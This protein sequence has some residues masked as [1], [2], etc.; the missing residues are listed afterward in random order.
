MDKEKILARINE[1]I[2]PDMTASEIIEVNHSPHPFTI[3]PQHIAH[4]SD[5]HG[6]ITR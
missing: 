3:G 1:I 6:G 4:A 5:N 2:A